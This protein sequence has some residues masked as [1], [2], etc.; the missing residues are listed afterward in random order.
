MADGDFSTGAEL[1]LGLA[2]GETSRIR[3]EIESE[4]A[5]ISVGVDAEVATGAATQSQRQPRDPN[6]GRFMAVEGVEQRLVEQTNVLEDL[7]ETVAVGVESVTE[8]LGGQRGGR[9]GQREARMDRR[10]FRWAMQRTEDVETIRA[11]LEDVEDDLGGGGFGLGGGVGGGGGGFGLPLG[12]G[13]GLGGGA[14]MLGGGALAATGAT[15]LTALGFGTVMDELTGAGGRLADAA[16]ELQDAAEAD[17]EPGERNPNMGNVSLDGVD[18]SGLDPVLRRLLKQEGDQVL[19]IHASQDARDVVEQEL[20]LLGVEQVQRFE[21]KLKQIEAPP[22]ITN[23]SEVFSQRNRPDWQDV[24]PQEELESPEPDVFTGSQQGQEM[25]EER[26]PETIPQEA[27][28]RLREYLN[29]QSG[30][31]TAVASGSAFAGYEDQQREE[32][33]GDRQGGGGQQTAPSDTGQRWAGDVSV[34]SGD[35]AVTVESDAETLIE[36]AI[37]RLEE[38]Q[39]QRIDDLRRD[40]ERELRR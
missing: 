16:V 9:V 34:D 32:V 23:M 10:E 21:E 40:L 18:L 4:L 26:I 28:E 12:L 37:E 39:D 27:Q 24:E 35:I 36:D 1:T 3:Q 22:W 20:E 5:D 8:S 31:R 6:T 38:E 14:S 15:A 17:V 7:R 2:S 29:R 33:M 25:I 13:F 11:L 19:Q 30:F